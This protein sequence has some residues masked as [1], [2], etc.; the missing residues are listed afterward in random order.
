MNTGTVHLA[1][2]TVA[3]V[4]GGFY[5]GSLS[6]SIMVYFDPGRANCLRILTQDDINNP[7][8]FL[9]TRQSLMVSNLG[10]ISDKPQEAGLSTRRHPW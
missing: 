8:L 1:P 10:L 7:D 3:R 9:H 4:T 2:A 5:L 6:Q